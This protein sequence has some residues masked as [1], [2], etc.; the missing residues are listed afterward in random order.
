[1]PGDGRTQSQREINRLTP[2]IREENGWWKRTGWLTGNS[3]Q[4]TQIGKEDVW[5]TSSSHKNL[6]RNHI[7]YLLLIA[8]PIPMYNAAIMTNYATNYSFWNV[9]YIAL[10]SWNLLKWKKKN[11]FKWMHD[12]QLVHTAQ[13][14]PMFSVWPVSNR[15]DG[16]WLMVQ[17]TVLSSSNAASLSSWWSSTFSV[18]PQADIL[19]WTDSARPCEFSPPGALA[20]SDSRWLAWRI[21]AGG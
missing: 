13:P 5:T 10:K 7:Y 21:Q 11:K 14:S 9:Q 6:Q 12:S 4:M 18:A 2:L 8:A 15:H 16:E 20:L 1:M 19:D 17:S 3:A